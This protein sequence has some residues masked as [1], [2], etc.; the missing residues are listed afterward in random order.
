M[1][2]KKIIVDDL[3]D[4]LLTYVGNMRRY[5]DMYNKVVGMYEFN[6]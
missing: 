6:N 4:N 2:E 3:Q 1:K 5:K